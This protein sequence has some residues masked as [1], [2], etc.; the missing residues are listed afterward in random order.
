MRHNGGTLTG[1]G[2]S[3]GGSICGSSSHSSVSASRCA[4]NASVRLGAGFTPTVSVIMYGAMAAMRSAHLRQASACCGPN[5]YAP[6]A[7]ASSLGS[8]VK[9]S[10]SLPSPITGSPWNSAPWHSRQLALVISTPRS[11]SDTLM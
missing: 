8:F 2:R 3:G 11:S 5:V 4:I 6:T 9:S 1:S 10:D 7:S